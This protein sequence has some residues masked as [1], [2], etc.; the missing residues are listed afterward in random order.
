MNLLAAKTK[1]PH[2]QHLLEFLYC[3]T[4]HGRLFAWDHIMTWID[5]ST[6][7]KNGMKKKCRNCFEMTTVRAVLLIGIDRERG[8]HAAA[9]EYHSDCLASELLWSEGVL[10][11]TFPPPTSHAMSKLLISESRRTQVILY[12]RDLVIAAYG[13]K[14][15]EIALTPETV[16]QQYDL[17]D[18]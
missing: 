9:F 6:C 2:L 15:T 18:L 7:V 8:R 16:C 5:Q 10:L 11:I 3:H 4:F 17:C 13:D 12:G 14:S 1:L